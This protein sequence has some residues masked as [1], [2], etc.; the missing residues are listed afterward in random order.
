M[1]SVGGWLGSTVTLCVF[2]IFHKLSGYAT[3]QGPLGE[4]T[5][6]HAPRGAC[7]GHPSEWFGVM[8]PFSRRRQGGEKKREREEKKKAYYKEGKMT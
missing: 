5:G 3:K 2:V 6:I 1:G 4:C 7:Q 8:E